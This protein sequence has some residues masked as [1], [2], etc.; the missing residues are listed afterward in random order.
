MN[1]LYIV[2]IS[3]NDIHGLKRTYDSIC[4]LNCNFIK[5]IV[6]DGASNDGTSDWLSELKPAFDYEWVSEKDYGIYNA[7]NKSLNFIPY[8]K[9]YTVFMNAGDEFH[10]SC[11]LNALFSIKKLPVSIIGNAFLCPPNVEKYMVKAR[12]PS[13]IWLGMPTSHQAMFFRNDF[14]KDIKYDES[15]KL[16]GDY[17]LYC[18]C[19]VKAL[20]E[21]IPIELID[22]PIC[23]FYMDGVSVNK[24]L[25]A[26]KEN[27]RTRRD[28]LKL[29]VLYRVSL[30]IAHYCHYYLKMSFPSLMKS[31]RKV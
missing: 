27:Y 11:F 14:L 12:G 24:R 16:G 10:N 26:L 2:T 9:D 4:N 15:F 21:N 20:E 25:S 18:I 6:I 19:V 29:N 3:Y 23:N 7:M 5:W 1:L 30:Y 8:D 13:L 31:I 28:V 17:N 22:Y